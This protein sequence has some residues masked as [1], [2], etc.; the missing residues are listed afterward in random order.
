MVIGVI[1]LAAQLLEPVIRRAADRSDGAKVNHR[2]RP[3]M[4]N[5]GLITRGVYTSTNDIAEIPSKHQRPVFGS[6]NGGTIDGSSG[7]QA[8]GGNE[9]CS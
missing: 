9:E 2:E 7:Q 6:Q 4:M 8:V 5:C 1:E 3:G